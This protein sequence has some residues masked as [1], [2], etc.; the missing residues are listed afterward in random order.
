LHYK[1]SQPEKSEK[2][3]L[4]EQS[5][6]EE[7]SNNDQDQDHDEKS[8]GWKSD[9]IKILLDYLQENFSSWSKGNKTKFYNNV[10]KNILPNKAS[11]YFKN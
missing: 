6:V 11:F 9:E 1:N 7:K 3:S 8:G 10:A 2:S 4:L 5:L